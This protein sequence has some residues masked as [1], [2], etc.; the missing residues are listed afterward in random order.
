[1]YNIPRVSEDQ[2]VIPTDPHRTQEFSELEKAK[3][4]AADHKSQ[5]DRIVVMQ[6]TES[7]QQLVERYTDGE[8]IAAQPA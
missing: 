5:F 3:E 1:M 4:F 6:V 2:K 8:H 7:E